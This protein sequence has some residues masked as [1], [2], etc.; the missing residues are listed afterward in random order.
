[1]AWAWFLALLSAG[2]T[3]ARSK[4]MMAMTTKS[5][6]RVKAF[7]VIILSAP[8]KNYST[9]IKLPPNTAEH[10]DYNNPIYSKQVNL[11]TRGFWGQKGGQEFFLRANTG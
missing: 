5:S 11:Q 6:I 9:L 7:F 1:M 4:A 3:T 10:I 2:I 8:S